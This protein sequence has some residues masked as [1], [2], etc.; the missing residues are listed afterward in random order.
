MKNKYT[1]TF[2]AYYVLQ[3][4]FP[5]TN[6]APSNFAPNCVNKCFCINSIVTLIFGLRAIPFQY[7]GKSKFFSMISI[8][9]C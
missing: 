1:D 9:N 7:Q 2:I 4:L 6:D 8:K 3:N 5:N